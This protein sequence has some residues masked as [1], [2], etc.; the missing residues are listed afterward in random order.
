MGLCVSAV[1]L[2]ATGGKEVELVAEAKHKAGGRVEA[3]VPVPEPGTV[4]IRF[5]NAHSLFT[6]K[7]V[8]VTARVGVA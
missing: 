3:Q 2:P 5:S 6:S 7:S 1:L 4:R 8:T